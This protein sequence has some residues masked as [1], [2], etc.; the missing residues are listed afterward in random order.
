MSAAI[1]FFSST[2]RRWTAR[3]FVVVVTLAVLAILAL[4]TFI[5][6]LVY[7]LLGS[8][9]APTSGDD[10]GVFPYFGY[11]VKVF[12]SGFAVYFVNSLAITVATVIATVLLSAMVAYPL[13]FFRFRSRG[14]I[15]SLFTLGLMIPYQVVLLPLFL[16][17]A[18]AG[19]LN[20]YWS[21]ILPMVAFG[22]PFSVFLM[23][24]FFRELDH[25][26]LEAAVIDGASAAR[27][28]W[29]IV[30]P[31]SRNVL[32]TVATLR[33]IFAWNEYLFAYTF[34]S[35]RDRLTL[36]LGLNDFIGAE[37]LVNWGPMFSA[38]A[39]SVLPALVAYIFLNRYMIAGLADG[40]TKE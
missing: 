11:Y 26:I 29:T 23:L 20:S 27:I 33:A 6:P 8:I 39:F 16:I 21:V 34:I 25:G 13:S 1:Q 40:A 15:E 22:M 36:V 35:S 2:R 7:T 17:Y 14:I 38:I 9:A 3:R 24:R 31:L 5:S 28:F 19:L 30:L 10:R 32:I 4:V 18:K 37:G 12:E